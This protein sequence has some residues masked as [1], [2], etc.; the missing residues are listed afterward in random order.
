LVHPAAKVVGQLSSVS[1]QR[2][3]AL[4]KGHDNLHV[5]LGQIAT[6]ACASSLD[7]GLRDTLVVINNSGEVME[8]VLGEARLVTNCEHNLSILVVVRHDLGELGEMPSVVL[9]QAHAELIQL[10]N[11]SAC[12]VMA[13]VYTYVLVNLVKRCDG[14]DDVV[15]LLLDAELDL[16]ARVRVAETE[17]GP[18]DVAGLKLL[19]ELARVLA[20][21]TE[22]VSDDFRGVAG[23]AGEV[24]ECG[25]DATRQILLA[26][27]DGDGL[28][29]SGFG[30][31]CLEGRTQEVG[32]DALADVVDLLQRIL[33][34][35][36]RRKA[37]KLDRLA[38]LV[39]VLDGLLYLCQ[40]T[41]NRVGLEDHLEDLRMAR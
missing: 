7:N 31:V 26:D 20:Q 39:E 24:G 16:G 38:K 14:L 23:L 10:L 15:V 6:H 25:L 30:Q 41:S 1:S 29:L 3:S 37:D 2:C 33:G 5:G 21:A 28:F 34:A 35:L 40:A 4:S 36:K 32:Q 11:V 12:L 27:A 8:V 17:D 13:D 18:V 22:Q 19:D 9:A